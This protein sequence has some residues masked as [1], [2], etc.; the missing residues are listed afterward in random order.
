MCQALRI[1]VAATYEVELAQD[2][3]IPLDSAL[4]Q[5]PKEEI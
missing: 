3:I 1:G 4:G 2:E 5:S